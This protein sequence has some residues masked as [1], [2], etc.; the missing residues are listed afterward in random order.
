MS[1]TNTI[2]T[3]I[4]LKYDTY[5][6]WMQSTLPI[7]PGEMAVALVF[8]SQNEIAGTQIVEGVAPNSHQVGYKPAILVKIGDGIL[9]TDS[10]T[11]EQRYK[12]FAE[13]DYIQ[14]RAGDVYEW[15]KAP[16][17]PTANTLLLGGAGDNANSTILS[18]I[19]ELPSVNTTYKI[20]MGAAGGANEG[21]IKL[22]SSTN[23]GNSWTDINVSDNNP[24]ISVGSTLVPADNTINISNGAIAAQISSNNAN[25]LVE[26]TT[27][28][29]EGLFIPKVTFSSSSSIA[30]AD[31]VNVVTGIFD[32]GAHNFTLNHTQLYTKNAIDALINPGMEFI[33]ISTAAAL[34][35][36]ELDETN[37]GNS[38]KISQNGTNSLSS[39][40]LRSAKTG[41]LAIV[42]Q[43]I[44]RDPETQAIIDVDYYWDVISSGNTN[45]EDTYRPMAINGV[46]FIGAG[47]ETGYLNILPGTGITLTSRDTDENEQHTVININNSS[48]QATEL[49][50]GIDTNTIAAASRV[51]TLETFTSYGLLGTYNDNGTTKNHTV[52]TYIDSKVAAIDVANLTQTTTTLTF[53]CGNAS[54]W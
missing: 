5:E 36:M 32:N 34:D 11:N 17:A 39:T 45:T 15:A 33:G 40:A 24:W 30:P 4:Q 14:T 51:S 6:N 29:E 21:K 9:V 35:I 18:K 28:G 26:K 54:G 13:L 42:C 20:V 8:L 7:L 12:T 23:G 37:V 19:N 31:S 3:R 53:N 38:Y 44:T 22:Q 43:E 2:N 48:V 27:T 47:I 1:L 25:A 10:I 52:K 46:E 16:T 41:D 50:I 49:I